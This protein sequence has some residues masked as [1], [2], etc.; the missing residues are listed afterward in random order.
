MTKLRLVKGILP[1][2]SSTAS[3]SIIKK[4]IEHGPYEIPNDKTFNGN[5]APGD[6][7]ESL[8]GGTKNNRDSPDLQD[9]EVKF[10]G[11]NA[12]LTLF[13]KEPSPR[14][15]IRYF[16]HEHGWLDEHNRISFRHTLGGESNRGFYVK[17]E[18]DRIVVRHKKVDSVVPYWLHN[19]LLNACSKLRRLI[20]V[21]GTYT[22]KPNKT[23][24]YKTATAYWNF[25][26][27]GFCQA[28]EKG[29]IKIDFD[30]RT[31]KEAGTAL[32]NHGTKFRVKVGDVKHFYEYSQIIT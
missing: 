7:L 16:V 18:A 22:E 27:M 13:H 8:F 25:D 14:G 31:K 23:V 3:F 2:K 5:A 32:R 24:I 11:G 30:A 6:Y 20:V 4:I 1:P 12:L 15:I 21:N 10:S 19:T 17:N 9:W 29:M 26:L 28:I